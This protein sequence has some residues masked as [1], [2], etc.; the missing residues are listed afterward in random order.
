MKAVVTVWCAIAIGIASQDRFKSGVDLARFDLF[1]EQDDHAVSGLA[2][3]DFEVTEG[4]TAISGVAVTELRDVPFDM[5]LVIQPLASHAGD[6][7]PL[8]D[9]AARATF[10]GIRSSDR[11]GVVV[12]SR[13]PAWLRPLQ[14]GGVRFD[15]DALAGTR[16]VV[17]LDAIASAFAEFEAAERRQILLTLAD[18]VDRLSALDGEMLAPFAARARPQVVFLGASPSLD[19]GFKTYA[20]EHAGRAGLERQ[21][22][23]RVFTNTFPGNALRQVAEVTGGR[24]VDLRSGDPAR[25]VADL[26]AR[27]RSGYVLT[28][29][30]SPVKGWHAVSI[31]A[32]KR[33]SRV[34]TRAGYSVQ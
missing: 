34:T 21:Y 5:V 27:L 33:G 3:E 13:P 6:Q 31:K 26:L 17:L 24:I 8:F 19:A 30:A 32:K 16:Q 14:P 22:S 1:V 18:G 29:P 28:F 7:I 10:E 12:A 20:V 23:E 4:G 15:P 11:F 2:V 25:L 9:R